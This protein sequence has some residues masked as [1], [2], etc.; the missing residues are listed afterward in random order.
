MKR[1]LS[2][3]LAVLLISVLC[4]VSV[5][6][7]IGDDYK[8]YGDVYIDEE[9]DIRLDAEMESVY[10][11]ASA[12]EIKY[13]HNGTSDEV[14]TSEMNGSTMNWW[15]FNGL[16]RGDVVPEGIATGTGYMVYDGE[17]LWLFV[18]IIDDDLTTAAPNALESSFRQDS[19]EFMM[20]WTNDAE[21]NGA[22]IYQA[23]MTHEGYIS[24]REG[25]AST[26]AP[27]LFG[28]ID[29]GGSNPVTWL[30]GDAKHTDKGWC[31]E[32]RIDVNYDLFD[33]EEGALSMALCINDYDLALEPTLGSRVMVC[34]DNVRGSADWLGSQYGYINFD[35]LNHQPSTGDM[36]IVYIAIA[37]VLA[38]G[39]AAG[40]V[41]AM[42]KRSAK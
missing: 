25:S 38:L 5:G 22:A 21:D 34:A 4:V 1:F 16:K 24:G 36:T 35:L 19:V 10:S 30:K 39:L 42:K 9:A 41:V 11:K 26:G 3:L 17:Y 18:D 14:I 6:A 20:D 33:A 29:D 27:A 40:T 31:C 28:S 7:R 37:M 23:R 2:C 15:R 13:V 8:C 32:F 12:W